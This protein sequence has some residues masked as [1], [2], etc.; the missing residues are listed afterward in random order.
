MPNKD[1]VLE[2]T[3][4]DIQEGSAGTSQP[5]APQQG[6]IVRVKEGFDVYDL[7]NLKNASPE[8]LEAI[9][10]LSTGFI[11]PEYIQKKGGLDYISHPH[12][13]RTMNAV[14]GPH[15]DFRILDYEV[16]DD[17]SVAA[18]CQMIV[19]FNMNGRD[20]E[21]TFIEIGSFAPGIDSDTGQPYMSVADR[22]GSAGSRGLL[23]CMFRA[24][25]YG[26]FLYKKDHVPM[27]KKKAW[28]LLLRYGEKRRGM[29]E[30]DIVKALKD[31]GFTQDN[32]V[33]GYSRAMGVIREASE[34]NPEDLPL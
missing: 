12:A 31:A 25:G 27:T 8:V 18:R 15:W 11:R 9:E 1:E 5:P 16:F 17:F 20:W 10:E 2:P 4:E 30:E 3:Y 23:K 7:A 6:E 21:R 33:E 28:G 34:E 32:L 14:F 13:T 29:T 22:I 19:R 24:F 26:A